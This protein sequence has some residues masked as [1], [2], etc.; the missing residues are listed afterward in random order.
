MYKRLLGFTILTA[1]ACGP[2]RH[3]ISQTGVLTEGTAKQAN[4]PQFVYNSTLI[5]GK[6]GVYVIATPNRIAVRTVGEHPW[7]EWNNDDG[8]GF[9][10]GE[11]KR[12]LE[13][14]NR[15]YLLTTAGFL[16]SF[17]PGKHTL[18]R[19]NVFPEPTG[20]MELMNYTGND[21]RYDVTV[22]DGKNVAFVKCP[23]GEIDCRIRQMDGDKL[24]DAVATPDRW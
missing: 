16:Y 14:G 17:T 2:A 20:E 23:D 8:R 3:E 22:V 10:K 21:G 4:P 6:G 9:I 5:T 13:T 24:E 11:T 7:T 1:V 18:R 19:I 12:I 15:V